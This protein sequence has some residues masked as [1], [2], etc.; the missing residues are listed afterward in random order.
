MKPDRLVIPLAA[1]GLLLPIVISVLVGVGRLL[2][3]MSDDAGALFVD[4]LALGVA[5][6][7]TI[8]L[9]LLLLIVALAVSERP[10]VERSRDEE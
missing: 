10:D 2:A 1:T 9:I 3:A 8:N 7:W 4:R 6:L 5:I